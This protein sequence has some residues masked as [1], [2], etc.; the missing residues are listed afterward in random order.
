MQLPGDRQETSERHVSGNA[1]SAES[2]FRAFANDAVGPRPA[3]SAIPP[4]KRI[5]TANAVRR[6]GLCRQAGCTVS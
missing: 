4:K 5:P 1:K 6:A 2:E 3:M